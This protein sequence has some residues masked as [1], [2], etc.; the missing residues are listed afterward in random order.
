VPSRGLD[1]D[2]EASEREREALS[3]ALEIVS[4]ER[5]DVHY[6]IRPLDKGRYAVSG[7]LEAEITQSCVVTLDTLAS[8][9]KE[10]FEAEYWPEAQGDAPGGHIDTVALD[11]PEF[12]RN[13]IVDIGSLIVDRLALAIDPYPRKPGAVFEWPDAADEQRRVDSP[14]A[15]LKNFTSKH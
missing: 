3:S 11:E 8:S 7:T 6:R 1:V 15:A 10:A 13:G 12:I 4:C 14:F 9:I 2:R 5:L